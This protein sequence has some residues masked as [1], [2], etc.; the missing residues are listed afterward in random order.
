MGILVINVMIVKTYII[1][2][3]RLSTVNKCKPPL[4]FSCKHYYK[5][6]SELRVL[7][8]PY[9]LLLASSLFIFHS[10]SCFVSFLVPIEDN[11]LNA[12]A[13]TSTLKDDPIYDLV[14]G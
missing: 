7:S 12:C 3:V 11:R 13:W 8:F 6:V 5:M 14:V 9:S 1:R 10:L 4:F 2:C